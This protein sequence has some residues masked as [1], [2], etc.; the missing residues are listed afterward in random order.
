ML[1]IKAQGEVEVYLHTF[2]L[3][4]LVGI[5]WSAS[6]PIHFSPG[7]TPGTHLIKGN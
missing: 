4:T 1:V 2:L 3:S 5:K 6:L 7:N